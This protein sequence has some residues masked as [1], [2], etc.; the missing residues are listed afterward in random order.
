MMYAI[1]KI[2]SIIQGELQQLHHDDGIEHLLLDSRHIVSPATSLFFAL[3]GPRRNGHQF[4]SEAYRKGI[5][6][7]VIDETVEGSLYSDANF[8]LV[9]NTLDALQHLAS[10]HRKQFNLPAIGITGSNG[11]TIVKEWLYQLLHKDYNIVR[12]PKSFNSQ[13][14]VPLSV[15]AINEKHS[16]AIFEAGISQP[17]EM[18]KL[19]AVILP[20]IGILT[21]IG[22]AHSEG[23]NSFTEKALEKIKLFRHCKKI[24]YNKDNA[25][26]LDLENE[27]KSFF[28][29]D[30]EFYSWSRQ[31]DAW[32]KIILIEKEYDH[33]VIKAQNQGREISIQIPFT[34]DASVENA[35]TCWCTL[36]A[37]KVADKITDVRMKILSAVNMRLDLK[38]GINHC[39]IINDSYSADLS[40]LE[41]AL[42]FLDQQSAASQK[43]IIISD[44]LQAGMNDEDLY[45]IIA[46]SLQQ[47]HINRLIGIGEKI[48]HHLA[49]ILQS[50]DIKQDYFLR[51]ES[52]LEQFRTT[53][54][55]EETILI[56][57]ARVFEFE[58]IVHLLE[59]KMHQTVLEINLNAI[60]HNLKE[61]Q[62]LV[63]PTTK[64]MAMVKA[65]AYGSGSAEI[66]GV[67]QFH[68]VDY[69]AVAYAD[70]GVELRKAGITLPIMVMN[71]DEN[72]F[73]TIIQNNLEPEIYS[74][75]LLYA[76]DIFLQKEALQQYP[77]H[78]ELE[79]G[80][81]RLGFAVEDIEAL[82]D[83]LLN[84]SS[85]RVQSVFSHLA[86]SEN[87][88]QDEFTSKQ[89]NL[90]QNAVQRL[91]NKL[92][93]SF[94][95]HI[96]NSAAI[97]RHP[98]MQLD[99]V[100]PGI[101]LYGVDNSNSTE[102]NLHTVTT[103]K[104]T[105]AQIKHLKTNESVG[106]NRSGVV[107][108]D[109]IVATVRI[110]YADGYPLA[111]SNGI[112]K[113]YIKEKFA[114]VIGTVCMDMTMIDVTDIPNVEEGNEV[115]VFGKELP[116]QQLAKWA[117]T[118]PY[119]IMTGVSQRVKRVY[120]EE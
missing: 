93:Y 116:V 119:E 47:H 18:E 115:V 22:Q 81:N 33:T 67:L 69:L 52:F 55:K 1:K 49:V 92:G 109:S 61:Y 43:T 27:D 26:H 86:A 13:V 2:S 17:G 107:S 56:K 100:R 75:K 64:I 11:K 72:S 8:I 111:L 104:S 70:E 45:E 16:S 40:S 89:F 73:D 101:G 105:I 46:N 44:F 38:K 71:P 77:F 90:F 50:S 114:P 24:I 65:F 108:K 78:I 99:M 23:F 54:F 57:G 6:N 29:T 106:Y 94:I 103:L 84:T 98:Q 42:N 51:A 102:L 39:T 20:T 10:Y 87:L 48:G 112:G 110:G 97:V 63:S 12:S 118:I 21:N 79:T 76:F 28:S 95:R 32:L 82:S 74:F 83:F 59:Q 31:Q 35:I 14:G 41:I 34:D 58:K 4:I 30:A 53:Q 60:V 117:Q 66:A 9:E 19:E 68:K 96:A 5:R 120:Y 3:K 113:I 36:L 91:Q 25:A 88:H 80:M 7:F 37:M 85:L 62:K 15:W